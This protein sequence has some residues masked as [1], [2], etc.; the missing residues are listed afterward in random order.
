ML[1]KYQQGLDVPDAAPEDRAKTC[2]AKA[3]SQTDG[4]QHW[5]GEPSPRLLLTCGGSKL[6]TFKI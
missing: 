6:N 5:W 3:R 2:K 4:A 1:L